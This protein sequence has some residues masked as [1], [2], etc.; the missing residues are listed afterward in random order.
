M[1]IPFRYTTRYIVYSGS[2][3]DTGGGFA[4]CCDDAAAAYGDQSAL[5]VAVPVG[6]YLREAAAADAGA[7]IGARSGDDSAVDG[8]ASATA[9]VSAADAGT[10]AKDIVFVAWRLN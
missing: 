6:A 7:A 3:A 9:E 8:D 1:P 5:T 4:T 10:T 2:A